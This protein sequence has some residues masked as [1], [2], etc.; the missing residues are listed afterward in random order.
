[1][2]ASFYEMV[3]S[4]FRTRWLHRKKANTLSFKIL[5]RLL[6]DKTRA[7]TSLALPCLTRSLQHGRSSELDVRDVLLLVQQKDW[8]RRPLIMEI[9]AL[10][11]INSSM[12]QNGIW[13]RLISGHG[14]CK[15]Q[16]MLEVAENS[17]KIR[18]K[19]ETR[20]GI[21]PVSPQRGPS[22]PNDLL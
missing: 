11:E 2:C 13:A 14:R 12:L 6:T 9:C 16:R 20:W 3:P 10:L 5:V 17:K 7:S 18:P 22:R 19:K 15:A 1:M 4:T 8:A 21:C